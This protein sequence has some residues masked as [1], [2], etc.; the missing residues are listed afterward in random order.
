MKRFFIYL[1]VIS[2][3]FTACQD[4]GSTGSNGDDETD[5]KKNVS[6]RN[7]FIN[8][9]N[10]YSDLF[11][12]STAM[13]KYIAEKQI[14]DSISRRMRS[15]YNTRNYQ[16]AWF[17]SDGL[18]EQARAFWNLHDYVTTYDRDTSLKDKALQ[19]KMDVLVAEENLS[20]SA[21]P[22]YIETELTLTQHFLRYMLNNYEK[23]YVKRKEMERFIP[24]I[25]R[26]P[27][28]VADSLLTKKHK[29]G[30][31]FEDV[32][33]PYRLLKEKLALYH[34]IVKNGGWPEIPA[35][36]SLK[37]GDSSATV[38][39]V[40]RR[41][42]L[43]GDMAGNDTSRIFNDTLEVAVRR[44]QQSM[45]YTP[46]G[47]IN[48]QLVKD[49]NVPPRL[50]LEQILLNME[51][52]RWMPTE[53]SGQLIMV[54]I[55]EFILHVYEGKQKAF[56]M[57][58]VVGKE[59]HNTVSF[60]GDLSTIV[61]SPYW[62]IPPSIVKNEILPAMERNPGYLESQNMEQTGTEGGLPVI[63]QRP[64][65][66]NS[67]GRVKFLFPNSFNIYFHDTPAKS[68]FNRDKR[69]Y[70]HGCIRLAEPEKMAQYLLRNNPEWTPEK[71][72]AAMSSNKEQYVKLSE[73]IPVIITYY[74]AWVDET[75]LLN[76]RED[77]YEHDKDLIAKA[78]L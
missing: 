53:P 55:P 43:S 52:M 23:G 16:F 18:T 68:L 30:K 62:N 54:N 1:T 75:G 74:T 40:K 61:F 5:E 69:A 71:I 65:P 26:D 48:A 56:T 76:F 3:L 20:A 17:S 41:L 10:S 73:P 63:R 58:V 19:K 72:S 77:I 78:F 66:K 44:F 13:E 51:R 24:Y 64:G 50:R 36:K 45:G 28:E 70:S 42:Q 49:M 4:A 9:E 25:K 6:K 57:N 22:S 33:E 59:G 27:L 47:V 46:S 15:F 2:T 37:K 11:L 38:T 12:D 14:P 39:L 67:L 34:G 29:D 8:K 31:Y 35:V 21:S 32:H 60:T 7:Y